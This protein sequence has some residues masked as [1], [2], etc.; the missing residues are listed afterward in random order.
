[1]DKSQEVSAPANPGIEKQW[2]QEHLI[3]EQPPPYHGN[4]SENQYP[5]GFQ[6]PP[7]P[8]PPPTTLYPSLPGN[9]LNQNNYKIKG[10][11]NVF[12]NCISTYCIQLYFSF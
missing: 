9:P 6:Q 3:Q 12:Y 1:M 10:T 11:V 4:G 8:G 2:I 7:P 5:G